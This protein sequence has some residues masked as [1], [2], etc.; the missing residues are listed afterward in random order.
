MVILTGAGKNLLD[1]MLSY[2][3]L[4]GDC[5][6]LLLKLPWNVVLQYST[7]RNDLVF[8]WAH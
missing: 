5:Y 7:C 1:I 2:L 4:F 3:A 8:K 6:I